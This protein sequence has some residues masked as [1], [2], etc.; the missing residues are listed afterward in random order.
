M[1][2]DADGRTFFVPYVVIIGGFY[3][4]GI[5][6]CRQ[7]GVGG[8]VLRTYIVPSLVKTFQNVGVLVFWGVQ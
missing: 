1:H 7:V 5:S 6:A 3:P 4:E 8:A 2:D